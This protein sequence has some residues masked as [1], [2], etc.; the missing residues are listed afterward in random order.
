MRVENN[1]VKSLFIAEDEQSIYEIVSKN[2][3]KYFVVSQSSDDN[4][5]S[6]ACNVS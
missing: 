6:D 1:Y 2:P 4:Y 5:V 3:E